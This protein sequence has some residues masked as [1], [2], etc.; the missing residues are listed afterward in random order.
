ML[1]AF[2]SITTPAGVAS[3]TVNFNGSWVNELGSKMKLSVA[4]DGKVTGKYKTAVGSPTE[5][6]EFDLVG[7]ATGDLI[8]FTVDFG[9][10]GSLTGWV[11]QHTENAN[12]AVIKTMWL[13]ARNVKDND[14]KDDL[15]G[16]VLTGSNDFTR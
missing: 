3:P 2:S 4:A 8:S 11:G 7:F 6:E 9:K 1:H 10:Y 5:K 14:E 12:G 16:A 13:L 15:W